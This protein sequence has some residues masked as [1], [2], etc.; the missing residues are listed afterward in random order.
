LYE[1]GSDKDRNWPSNEAASTKNDSKTPADIDDKDISPISEG[2][3]IA[4][5]PIAPGSQ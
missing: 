2:D 1:L 5:V 3:E 4:L